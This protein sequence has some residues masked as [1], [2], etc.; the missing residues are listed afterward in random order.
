MPWG[1]S[2]ICEPSAG[3][4]PVSGHFFAEQAAQDEPRAPAP[5]VHQISAYYYVAPAKI[6][7]PDTREL[8][9]WVGLCG[10][11]DM[12]NRL[13]A[14]LGSKAHFEGTVPHLCAEFKAHKRA[15]TPGRRRTSM[16]ST[17]T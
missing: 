6:R 3:D 5:G 16:G 7:D 14:L 10:V 4:S 17:W 1:I 11:S 15:N 9:T 8:K 13:A 2:P 12:L